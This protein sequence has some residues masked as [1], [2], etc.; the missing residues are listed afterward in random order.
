MEVVS[1]MEELQNVYFSCKQRELFY[2]VSFLQADSQLTI[3]VTRS[4]SLSTHSISCWK[5]SALVPFTASE[6]ALHSEAL[7]CQYIAVWA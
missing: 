1:C 6:A 2:L 7:H 4:R 3:A 5:L